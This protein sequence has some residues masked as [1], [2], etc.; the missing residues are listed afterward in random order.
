MIRKIRWGVIGLCAV[1]IVLVIIRY[2][3]RGVVSGDLVVTALE[4]PFRSEIFLIGEVK[5]VNTLSISVQNPGRLADIVSEGSVVQEDEPV[6]WLE[7]EELERNVER[8]RIDVEIAQKRLQK[9]EEN[10]RLQDRLNLLAIEEAQ[11]RLEYQRNQ[12]ATTESRLERT[13]RLVSAE[14]S[15]RQAL[16]DAE[17]EVLSQTLQVQNAELN[18]EKAINNRE[19]Q[20]ELQRADITTAQIELDKNRS[21]LNKALSGLESAVIRAPASGMVLYRNIW[22]GGGAQEKVAIGD[23]IGPWQP[24]MEIPDLSELEVVTRVDEIDISRLHENQSATIHLD[25]FPAMLLTGTVA[26]IASLA[27]DAAMSRSGSS[28]EGRK[29]FE[30]GIRIEESPEEL[31]PGITARATVLLHHSDYEIYV[32]IEAV[33]TEGDDR[34]VFISAFGG[35]E[36]RL[37]KTGVWNTQHI[38]IIEGLDAGQRILLVRPDTM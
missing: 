13:R 6:A 3:G 38:T 15:P 10:A 29:V 22:K 5:A 32:P 28:E 7:T 20:L 9:V 18:L 16:D 19:S 25:A 8:Y 2:A 27:E 21:E 33:F 11:S 14:I 34:F 4:G 24:F 1:I 36:K 17:L 12:L 37:V 35:P 26:R 23:Q 31:R 30:V